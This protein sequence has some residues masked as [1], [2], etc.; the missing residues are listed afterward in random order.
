MKTERQKSFRFEKID[1]EYSRFFDANKTKEVNE[2]F[3]KRKILLMDLFESC[4]YP[5]DKINC[6]LHNEEIT[7]AGGVKLFIDSCKTYMLI[8]DSKFGATAKTQLVYDAELTLNKLKPRILKVVNFIKDKEEKIISDK[9]KR[10]DKSVFCKSFLVKISADISVNIDTHDIII[11]NSTDVIYLE[12]KEKHSHDT[13][14][15]LTFDDSGKILLKSDNSI[16]S[17][18]KSGYICGDG[19]FELI[20]DTEFK[21]KRYMDKMVEIDT[22]SKRFIEIFKKMRK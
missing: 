19:A 21:V 11:S 2:K 17:P 10:M 13:I 12:Y 14:F 9:L 5:I 6:E 20:A 8:S 16:N 3:E 4:G 22:L 1:T 15:M 7:L 18:L